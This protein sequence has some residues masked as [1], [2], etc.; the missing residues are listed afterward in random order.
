MVLSLCIICRGCC[1]RIQEWI[2]SG[3]LPLRKRRGKT[4]GKKNLSGRICGSEPSFKM[5]APST[6][7]SRSSLLTTGAACAVHLNH[8]HHK[9]WEPRKE[10]MVGREKMTQQTDDPVITDLQGKETMTTTWSHHLMRETSSIS[11]HP[12]LRKLQP[13]E[14][15]TSPAELGLALLIC[16]ATSWQCA[17]A[18]PPLL[19]LTPSP[20][21]WRCSWESQNPNPPPL[22]SQTLNPLP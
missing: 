5:L 13:P 9:M 21:L 12:L 19:F 16:T 10:T 14:A 18:L 15:L 1:F 8:D 7:F 22:N 2:C 6:A 11:Q 17:R 3:N 20:C 4:V